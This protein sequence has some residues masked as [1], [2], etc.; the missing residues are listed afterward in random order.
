MFT[1]LTDSCHVPNTMESPSRSNQTGTTCGRPSLR[2]VASL[3]VRAPSTRK[4]LH[5]PIVI[6]AI[7]FSPLL[8]LPISKLTGPFSLIVSAMQEPRVSAVIALLNI[9]DS[10]DEGGGASTA[11]MQPGNSRGV[12]AVECRVMLRRKGYSIGAF[13]TVMQWRNSGPVVTLD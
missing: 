4:A 6:F 11:V 13:T 8:S 10:R 5:S 2:T 7:D 3:A 9:G 1:A 12:V